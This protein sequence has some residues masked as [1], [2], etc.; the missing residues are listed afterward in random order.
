MGVVEDL[1]KQYDRQIG[2]LRMD[3]AA[4]YGQLA[5]RATEA[6][7]LTNNAAERALRPAV[8]MR[9]ITGGNRSQAGAKAWA[10]L[11]SVMRTIQQQGLDLV[12]AIKTLLRATWAGKDA[13]LLTELFDTS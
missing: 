2:D 10:I 5:E 8:V 11:A 9:K 4:L 6:A 7:I 3:N 1:T 13:V 12:E